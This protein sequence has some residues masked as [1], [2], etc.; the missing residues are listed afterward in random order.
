VSGPWSVPR[1]SVRSVVL[2]TLASLAFCLGRPLPL[3]AQ[4]SAAPSRQAEAQTEAPT[5]YLMTMG[6]GQLVW[7]RFGHNALWIHDPVRGTDLTYNYGLFDLGQENF[8]LRFIQGRML[9]WMDGA[10]VDYYLRQYRRDNRSIWVQELDL[11]TE[12]R[13][14]LQAFLAWNARPEN[15]HYR[16]DY[17]RDNCSTR[18]RDALDRVLGGELRAQTESV[19]VAATYRSH[20]RRL[21]ANDVPIYT[22]LFVA[23]GPVTDRPL[24]AWDEMFLPLA[25]REHVRRVTVRGPDGLVKPLVKAERTIYES[26]APPPPAEPPSWLVWYLAFGVA[27]G[28][29]AGALSRRAGEHRGARAML[30][31]VG[32]AWGLAVGL[33]GIVLAG[34]WLAT[35]HA[36]TYRNVNLFQLN[37]VALPLALLIPAALSGRGWA[38]RL[39]WP[40]AAAAA[41]L[42]VLGVA[43]QLLPGIDQVNGSI[44]ALMLPIHLGMAFAARTIGRQSE[45]R[46]PS[47]AA[48]TISPGA[49]RQA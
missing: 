44:V 33:A 37:P 6:P 35:D 21:T 2:T 31:G 15:R 40:V 16:Y 7:E 14:E 18:V 41:V 32:A 28:V 45:N 29:A 25:M 8:I 9:Y 17:Y 42:S 11:P 47:L 24:S 22:G 38:R 34:L 10:P 5:V 26:T 12:T 46:I 39:V 13:L 27:V 30:A 20:T 3:S 49:V 36:A 19:A 4:E 43:L 48:S 1:P 23:L